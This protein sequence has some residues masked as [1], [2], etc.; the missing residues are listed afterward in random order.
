MNNLTTVTQ[1]MTFNEVLGLIVGICGLFVAV[2]IFM[3]KSRNSV[4]REAHEESKESLKHSLE[5]LRLGIE[6][7]R[8]HGTD[9]MNT[10]W[11][12]IDET[13]KTMSDHKQHISKHYHDK[14]EVEKHIE[15]INKPY[16]QQVRHLNQKV[17]KLEEKIEEVAKTISEVKDVSNQV[18]TNLAI[19][20][21]KSDK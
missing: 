14:Q 4:A 21:S 16:L 18:L 6:S 2:V 8:K 9:I 5:T 11:A 20:T 17:D 19:L 3:Q 7:N 10:M 15:I 13:R 12:R 1:T